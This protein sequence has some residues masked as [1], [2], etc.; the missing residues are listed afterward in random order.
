MNDLRKWHTGGKS[1]QQM[2][3]LQNYNVYDLAAQCMLLD[4]SIEL[5]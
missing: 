4:L 1:Y 5:F 3:C 2:I